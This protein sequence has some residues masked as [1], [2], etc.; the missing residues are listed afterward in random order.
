MA[1]NKTVILIDD[2]TRSP[3]NFLGAIAGGFRA[4]GLR[5]RALN[6]HPGPTPNLDFRADS[7]VR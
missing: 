3:S 5:E 4:R 6:E 7:F 2:F 1:G